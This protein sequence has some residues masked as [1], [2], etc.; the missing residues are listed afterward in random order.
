MPQERFELPTF[1]SATKRAIHCAIGA[2]WKII[3]YL[4]RRLH[5]QPTYN[6]SMAGPRRNPYV[7]GRALSGAR[8]FCGREDV[9]RVVQAELEQP[10]HNAIVLFG[11]RRIGKT[12][13]LLNLRSRLPTPPFVA[14]YFDLMDRAQ[15]AGGRL[16]RDCGHNRGRIEHPLTSPR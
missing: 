3:A 9:F 7:A 5:V 1:W 13:I 11:Q 6:R 4:S 15:V 8:G 12:S 16:V 2:R 14:V 10:D